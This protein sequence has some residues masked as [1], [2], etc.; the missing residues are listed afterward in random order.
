MW[1]KENQLYLGDCLD[2][3]KEVENNS[4]DLILTDV[5]YG[6]D[7]AKG[8][9]YDD[10]KEYVFSQYLNWLSEMY[11]VLKEGSHCYIFIP[12]LEADKWIGGVKEVGFR[13]N[14]ILATRTYTQSVYLKNNFKFD[15]QLV[16][17]CSKWTA[18]KLNKVD[19]IP[20]SESWLKDKRNPNPKPFTYSYPSFLNMFSN[21]KANAKYKNIHWNEKSIEFC[22]SLIRLSSKEGELVLDPFTWS[23]TTLI[24]AELNNRKFLW[25]EKNKENYELALRNMKQK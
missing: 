19:W 2:L 7:F 21:R 15:S 13:F 5:P 11:R 22:S 23:G 1:L 24:C 6:V 8:K 25:F 16:L 14:N 9:K 18:K 12:N 17:Y 20:T 4:V 10:S 3:F